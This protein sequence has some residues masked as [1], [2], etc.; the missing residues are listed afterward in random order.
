MA[1]AGKCSHLPH[2]RLR[3]AVG[4]PLRKLQKR[5]CVER[6][7]FRG[8]SCAKW[9]NDTSRK[10]TISELSERERETDRERERERER[11]ELCGIA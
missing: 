5:H 4:D 8:E 2:W 6:H 7:R 3:E 1:G 9:R 10:M 11:A